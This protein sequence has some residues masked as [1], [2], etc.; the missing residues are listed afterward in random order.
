MVYYKFYGLFRKCFKNVILCYT[1]LKRGGGQNLKLDM[2][3]NFH[4]ESWH[5]QFTLII[6]FWLASD[7]WEGLRV[8]MLSNETINMIKII[9][10]LK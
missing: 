1:Y 3:R 6:S 7:K 8:Q 5:V 4:R 10:F 2:I 9:F